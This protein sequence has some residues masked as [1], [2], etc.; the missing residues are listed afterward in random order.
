MV[1]FYAANYV[2]HSTLQAAHKSRLIESFTNLEAIKAHVKESAHTIRMQETLARSL[3]QSLTTS[4]FHLLNGALSHIFGDIFTIFII[5]FGAQAVLQNQITL[6]QLVAFHL[7]AGNVSGPILSLASL[8]EEWQHLKISRLRL[9]DILN[10]P[11]EWEEEKPPFNSPQA[12]NLKPKI[13]AFLM[14]KHLLLTILI[15]V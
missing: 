8:W 10:A 5:F 12:L 11:S 9:G 6:G 13:S 15:F 14:E 2:V 3:D 1:P 7:L 4:K